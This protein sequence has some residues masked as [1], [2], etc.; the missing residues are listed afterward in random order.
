MIALL[1]SFLALEKSCEIE[2]HIPLTCQD[3]LFT[4]ETVSPKYMTCSAPALGLI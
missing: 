2:F 3:I 4:Q 1:K